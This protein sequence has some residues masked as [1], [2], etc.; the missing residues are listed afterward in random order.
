[1]GVLVSE[2]GGE[3][4][5]KVPRLRSR[6]LFLAA[7]C[8]IVSVPLVRVNAL[9]TYST[10]MPSS[11]SVLDSTPPYV[12][13]WRSANR[14]AMCHDTANGPINGDGFNNF[15]RTVDA[16]KTNPYG[17]EFNPSELVSAAILGQNI[18]SDGDAYNN[19]DELNYSNPTSK[20]FPGDAAIT[21]SLPSASALNLSTPSDQPLNISTADLP[22]ATD[23][24]GRT[25]VI[26]AVKDPNGNFIT[27]T[28]GVF[29]YIPTTAVGSTVALSYSV[30]DNTATTN[31]KP[32]S[33]FATINVAINPP[34]AQPSLS[35]AV[36]NGTVIDDTDLSAGLN[37]ANIQINNGGASPVLSLSGPDA[38]LFEILTPPSGNPVLR[39]AARNPVTVLDSVAQPSLS[40]TVDLSANGTNTSFSLTLSVVSPGPVANND[41]ITTPLNTS[42][43]INV[44]ANDVAKPGISSVTITTPPGNGTATLAANGRD[45]VYTPNSGYTGPDS[46]QYTITAGTQNSA[47]ATV[48]ITVP[49]FTAGLIAGATQDPKLKSVAQTLDDTCVTLDADQASTGEQGQLHNICFALAA[50][51]MNG[52]GIDPALNAISPE[53]AFAASDSSFDIW[54]TVSSNISGRLDKLRHRE[55]SGGVDVASLNFASANPLMARMQRVALN[56]LASGVNKLMMRDGEVSQRRWGFF[57]AGDVDFGRRTSKSAGGKRSFDTYGITSGIDY[58]FSDVITA[59][60]ALSYSKLSTDFSGVASKLDVESLTVTGYGSASLGAVII[61]GQLG[62]AQHS[63]DSSRE[64]KFIT[65]GISIDELATASYKGHDFSASARATVPIIVGPISIDAQG[66]VNY[67]SAFVSGY[68]ESGGN[69]LS[70]FLKPEKETYFIGDLGVNSRLKLGSKENPISPYLAFKYHILTGRNDR[71]I[72]AGFVADPLQRASIVLRS[73]SDDDN[74]FM[75]VNAGVDGM[76]FGRLEWGLGYST[77]FGLSNYRSNQVTVLLALPF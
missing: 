22:S 60:M 26:S 77:I 5:F 31:P 17:T 53:E 6:A 76:S 34:T 66:G 73:Q 72:I 52:K 14:C 62:L 38:A 46:F 36:I 28:G 63:F 51:V 50:D 58:Q 29:T 71:R 49:T 35:L 8:L 13:A 70:L 74:N 12:Q 57:V 20:F 41:S 18:N 55:G 4:V 64:I 68:T 33:S 27:P 3:S 2:C 56:G 7:G 75:S 61:D 10:S 48:S 21:P 37:V 54:R 44:T 11:G 67:I 47:P 45:I 24:L 9:P 19:Y 30:Q 25:L 23:A 59:G 16:V 39:L 40:V 1:M 42:V 32:T 43:T 65:N 15:G 69:G